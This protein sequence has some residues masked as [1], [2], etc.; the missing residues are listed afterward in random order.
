[1]R[2]CRLQLLGLV[3]GGIRTEETAFFHRLR[4]WRLGGRSVSPPPRHAG[5]CRKQINP[6]RF[7]DLLH[8]RILGAGGHRTP[9]SSPEAT[10]RRRDF[11]YRRVSGNR[12]PGIRWTGIP[13]HPCGPQRS[14]L[15]S[16]HRV[17]R[18]EKKQQTIRLQPRHR[19]IL[20][21]LCKGSSRKAIAADLGVSENT[22][23]G[24]VKDIFRHFH[25]NSQSQLIAHFTK[26]DD[27]DKP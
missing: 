9:H 15:A 21:L 2:H 16:F 20:K 11:R 18:T 26:G 8:P 1:M 6:P 3:H 13:H 5:T 4:A 27:G 17:P 12:P 22:V 24:Y 23:H 10:A 25:V 19:T 14:F 7:R